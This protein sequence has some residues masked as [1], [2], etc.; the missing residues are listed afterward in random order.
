[1]D[2]DSHM[3]IYSAIGM[4]SDIDSNIHRCL[5]MAI[6]NYSHI[7]RAIERAIAIDNDRHRDIA[8][9]IYIDIALDTASRSA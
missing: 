7:D 1:M 2:I 8:P 5:N 9:Y 6:P 4:S 3:H